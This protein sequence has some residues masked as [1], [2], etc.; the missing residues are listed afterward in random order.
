MFSAYLSAPEGDYHE[1]P[2]AVIQMSDK[3]QEGET[4]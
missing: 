3:I 1:L 2:V 4:F